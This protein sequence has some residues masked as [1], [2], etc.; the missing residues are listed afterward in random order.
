MNE[1][2]VQK[3]QESFG[4]VFFLTVCWVKLGYHEGLLYSMSNSMRQNGKSVGAV[5]LAVLF[6]EMN[7]RKNKEIL[8]V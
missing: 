3:L 1:M 5:F 7:D 6:L 8:I 2:S 4:A